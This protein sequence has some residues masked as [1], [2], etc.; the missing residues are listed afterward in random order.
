[1]HGKETCAVTESYRLGNFLSSKEIFYG[2]YVSIK[3]RGDWRLRYIKELYY[4]NRTPDIITNIKVA[5][6]GW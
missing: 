4:L 6:L 1:M 5:R 3:D 2:K